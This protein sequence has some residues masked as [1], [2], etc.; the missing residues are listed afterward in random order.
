MGYS[1]QDLNRMQTYIA[2]EAPI[3]IH[4]NLSKSFQHFVKDTCYRNLFETNT[5]GGGVSKENRK[6]WEKH[7]FGTC[8]D[9]AKD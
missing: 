7:L 5:S 8:Y 3:N 1:E 6:I 9:E 4:F 2:E